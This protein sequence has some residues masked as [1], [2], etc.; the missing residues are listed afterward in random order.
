MIFV[1]FGHIKLKFGNIG[2]ISPVNDHF[3]AECNRIRLTADGKIKPCLHSNQEILATK[4]ST[5]LSN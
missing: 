2:F 4:D 5:M 3:C 1:C